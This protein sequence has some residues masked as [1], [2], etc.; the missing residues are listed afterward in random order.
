MPQLSYVQQQVYHGVA[1]PACIYSQGQSQ[2]KIPVVTLAPALSP[3][4]AARRLAHRQL[5]SLGGLNRRGKIRMLPYPDIK[6][7]TYRLYHQT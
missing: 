3:K 5:F 1:R 6:D 7:E 4:A 2:A